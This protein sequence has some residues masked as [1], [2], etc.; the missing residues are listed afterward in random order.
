LI[1]RPDPLAPRENRS[2]SY[3]Q[4]YEKM[5]R[6]VPAVIGNPHYWLQYAM[7]VMSENNLEDAE[8]ILDTAYA[9]ASKNPDYDT[10]YIDNQYARLRLKQ[11]IREVDQKA[12]VEYFSNAH[13]ILKREENDVYKFRQAE[14]YIAYY[15]EKYSSLSKGDKVKYEH[16]V[17]EILAHYEAYL[18]MEYPLGDVPPFQVEKIDEFR[19][20]VD[21]ISRERTG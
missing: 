12:S 8:R 13:K 18:D 1:A 21:K 5:K 10:T 4:F 20:V 11:A 17:K 19:A 9:K 2:N 3:I 16:A 15:N 6:E 14:L 7:A